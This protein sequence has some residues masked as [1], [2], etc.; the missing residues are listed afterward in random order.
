MP[1]LTD[2]QRS[3]LGRWWTLAEAGA[4]GGFLST[5]I[6]AAA[7]DLA[8]Q[9]GSALSFGE[10]RDLAVLYGYGRRM[11]NAAGALGAADANAVIDFTMIGVPPWAR[12][13]Q[14]MNTTPIWHVSFDFSYIDAAGN[15]VTDI[16]T[17]VFE[18]TM[19]ETVGGLTD[20]LQEDAQALA[21]KYN[22]EL[23]GIQLRE[24][25]AV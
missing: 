4:Y 16:R 20:A 14:V 19:P 18:M 8:G 2:S 10:A 12:D 21:D 24:I 11:A 9:Q 5:D 25:L 15:A 13:E 3:A 23:T 17:S 6:V 22:V 7:S 1:R